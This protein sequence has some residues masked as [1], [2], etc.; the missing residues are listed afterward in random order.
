MRLMSLVS[1]FRP[2]SQSG[3]LDLFLPFGDFLLTLSVALYR[4]TRVPR[5]PSRSTPPTP[6]NA[7]SDLP[8]H[9]PLDLRRGQPNPPSITT[10][11]RCFLSFFHPCWRLLQPSRPHLQPLILLR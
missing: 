4:L 6:L 7:H 2:L 11:P 3:S 10:Q 9:L 5:H 8:L 1:S